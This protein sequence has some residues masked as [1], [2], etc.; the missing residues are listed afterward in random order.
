MTTRILTLLGFLLTTALASY[1][2]G[3]TKYGETEE[4]QLQCKEALQ[5]YR[6][7]KKQG[8]DHDA[9]TFWQRVM[10]QCPSN[11]SQN[12]YIDGAKFIKKELKLAKGT[13]RVQPLI[14]SLWMV[15]DLRMEN[16][17]STKKNPN[18]KC[19]VLG[20][21]SMDYVKLYKKKELDAFPWLEESVMCTQEKSQAAFV[22]KYYELLGKKWQATE[23]GAEKEELYDRLLNEYLLL[24]GWMDGNIKSNK[25]IVAELT[26]VAESKA[27]KK[28]LSRGEKN[29]SAYT[30]GKKN[31][32]EI[33]VAVATCDKMLPV[34]EQKIAASPDDF[35]LKKR[36]LRLF[37]KKDCTESD[38]YL[39][40]AE[41]VCAAEPDCDCKYSLA[42]AYA[43]RK[44]GAKA[45]AFM[46]EAMAMCKEDPDYE[47]KLEKA[48]ILSSANGKHSKAKGYAREL[49]R[50][51]PNNG[52]AY[53][54]IGDAT[55]ASYKQCQD[56]AAG[57]PS[58]FWVAVDYYGKAKSVDPEV[59]EKANRRIANNSKQFPTRADLFNWGLKEGQTFTTCTGET[60][61]VRERK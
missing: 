15:Y 30:K 53:I 42:L 23:D 24:S 59:A 50:L 10:V 26:D 60:T 11:V 3:D 2:Q 13:D 27:D 19:T 38:L 17:P 58:M 49:L 31:L 28:K 47:D 33:F 41:D 20:Y 39:S 51:N 48:A 14:D 6:N 37:N 35:E 55:A 29:L 52:Q 18:N 1:A 34:M 16:F 61:K 8:L 40:L 21:K 54:V 32:D 56:G 45:L 46:E 57:G 7:Y 12:V 5:L 22:S 43:K 25:Q 36:A 9:Y 44:E 4:Q